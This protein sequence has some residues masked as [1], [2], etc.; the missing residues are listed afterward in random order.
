MG[1]SALSRGG[2]AAALVLIAIYVL[3]GGDLPS[4]DDDTTTTSEPP[5]QTTTEAEEVPVPDGPSPEAEQ[6]PADA[7]SISQEEAAE[8]KRVLALVEA[9][10]PF[11]HDQ[12]GTTFQNREGLLPQQSEGYYKEYTCETPGSEDRGARRLVIGSGG[13]TYYTADHYGSFTRIDPQDYR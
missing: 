3:L 1:R 13:E 6:P 7:G 2:F 9:G 8:I 11:S 12:D 5:P 4:S 10:G